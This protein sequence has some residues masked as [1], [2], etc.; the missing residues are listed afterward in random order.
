M[1]E[2]SDTECVIVCPKSL[3][4]GDENENDAADD[5]RIPCQLRHPRTNKPASYLCT[6]DAVCEV[7]YFKPKTSCWFIGERVRSDGSL[8]VATPIDPLFLALPYLFH[9]AQSSSG[10]NFMLLD[11]TLVDEDFEAVSKRLLPTMTS[12]VCRNQ[13]QH[14]ADVKNIDD[15]DYP[16]V[17]FN[18]TKTLVWLERKVRTLGETLKAKQVD[19]HG[20]RSVSL[21]VPAKKGDIND[22]DDKNSKDGKV[23]EI[24]QDLLKYAFEVV[25]DYLSYAMKTRLAKHLKLEDPEAAAISTEAA[26]SAAAPPAAKKAKIGGAAAEEPAEDYT[27]SATPFSPASTNKKPSNSKA[28]KDLAKASKG[29]ASVMSFFKAT[30]KK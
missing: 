10:K 27:K 16:A 24:S 9:A 25:C 12:E 7:N 23:E 8:L 21:I 5:C 26:A 3:S 29:T 6:K 19:I 2:G 11:Q 18:E 13:L 4:Q 28:A 22:D 30:P 1:G 17:R 20:S 15:S 14:I